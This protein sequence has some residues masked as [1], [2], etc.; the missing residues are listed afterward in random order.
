MTLSFPRLGKV[1]AIISLNRFS[2]PSLFSF[3]LWTPKMKKFFHIMMP[4]SSQGASL[5]LLIFLS[6]SFFSFKKKI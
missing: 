6:S 3:P 1:L 5:F 4:Q 2:M